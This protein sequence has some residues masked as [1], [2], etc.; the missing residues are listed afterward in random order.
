MHRRRYEITA[1]AWSIIEPLLPNKPR[2]VPRVDDRKVLTGI[3][4]RLRTGAPWADIAQRDGPPTTGYNRFLAVAQIGGTASSK[5]SR[6]P[7]RAILR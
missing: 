4:W 2:G 6:P 3:A 1:V 7:T 5:R